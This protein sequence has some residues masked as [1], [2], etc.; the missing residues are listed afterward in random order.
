MLQVIVFGLI[1]LFIIFD[2]IMIS[3]LVDCV[4]QLIIHST[5]MYNT[6]I[7]LIVSVCNFN[8]ISQKS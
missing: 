3:N 2:I 6:E 5:G 4:E 8:H 1:S 7:T